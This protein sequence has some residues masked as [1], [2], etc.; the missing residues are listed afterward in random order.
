ML[1]TAYLSYRLTESCSRGYHIL[2]MMVFAV[3]FSCLSVF[4]PASEWMFLFFL[5]HASFLPVLSFPFYSWIIELAASEA[6][7]QRD[8]Y[9]IYHRGISFLTAEIAS[10][11]E[12]EI[13]NDVLV[14]HD[15][16][17]EQFPVAFIVFLAFNILG[18]LLG[19]WVGKKYRT[20]FFST[21]KWLVLCGFIGVCILALSLVIITFIPKPPYPLP[22][23]YRLL[24][25]NL[26]GSMYFWF[27]II[28]LE[29]LVLPIVHAFKEVG[30]RTRLTQITKIMLIRTFYVLQGLFNFVFGLLELMKYL[31]EPILGFSIGFL[32][33]LASCFS[34]L[35]AYELSKGHRD[36]A[37]TWGTIS[38]LL[39]IILYGYGLFDYRHNLTT[40][41][42][43]F[44]FYR[45]PLLLNWVFIILNAVSILSLQQ[46]SKNGD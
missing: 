40:L 2:V 36:K 19:Y 25:I 1:L 17:T 34:F 10:I 13:Q 23:S 18:V 4:F 37:L 39:F 44:G 35:M 8:I 41:I 16:L 33:V 20:K 45:S 5:P 27:N 15:L 32:Y 22:L 9:W 43:I 24:G 12:V 7:R 46:M 14:R 30:E 6:L 38:S 42:S 29:T 11:P 21:K 31:Y 3:A 26:W 28:F